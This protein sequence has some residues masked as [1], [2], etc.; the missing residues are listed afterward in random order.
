M[1]NCMMFHAAF[2]NFSV[3]TITA[4]PGIVTSTTGPFILTPAS[5]S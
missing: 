2:N 1:I 3:I 5:K 4:F